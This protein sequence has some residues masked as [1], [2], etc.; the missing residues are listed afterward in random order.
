MRP[1]CY[2]RRKPAERSGAPS[3]AAGQAARSRGAAL[4]CIQR[5]EGP[6]GE[7]GR[8]TIRS[9]APPPRHATR[10]H[11][12]RRFAERIISA[13]P[14]TAV[15]DAQRGRRRDIGRPSRCPRYD[16]RC[17]RPLGWSGPRQWPIL[18]GTTTASGPGPAG[19]AQRLDQAGP[20]VSSRPPPRTA[21]RLDHCLVHAADGTLE[22]FADQD[23]LRP[24]FSSRATRS[25][26]M[27]RW[28]PACR[29]G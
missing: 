16:D 26:T 29:T 20:A 23:P 1:R 15:G 3:D 14:G 6:F 27:S 24:P 2:R 18:V 21:E 5:F 11:G 17:P 9:R 10:R 19:R 22:A 7:P 28:A 25:I 4:S 8:F 12:R 13:I